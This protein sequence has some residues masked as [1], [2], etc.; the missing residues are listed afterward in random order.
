MQSR[1]RF[2]RY[3][4]VLPEDEALDW[5][6]P[7]AFLRYES[8]DPPLTIEPENL[9]RAQENERLG[10]AE[11][12]LSIPEGSV[13][14]TEAH[15]KDVPMSSSAA[16]IVDIEAARADLSQANVLFYDTKAQGRP[17]KPKSRA[18]LPPSLDFTVVRMRPISSK[19][20]YQTS[21]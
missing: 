12:L 13:I 17:P 10:Y 14:E 20:L 1:F 8:T 18:R 16:S 5:L 21:A 2:R 7:G 3:D 9:C 6:P 19:K 11:T 15:C 4:R